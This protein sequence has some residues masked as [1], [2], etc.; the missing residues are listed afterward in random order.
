MLERLEGGQ[1]PVQLAKAKGEKGDAE[2]SS[3]QAVAP[4]FK[5]IQAATSGNQKS[6]FFFSV[7]IDPLE[8]ILPSGIFMNFIENNQKL[9]YFTVE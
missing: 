8:V 9:I 7:I 6:E 3:Q 4:F 1:L 5:E 2:I